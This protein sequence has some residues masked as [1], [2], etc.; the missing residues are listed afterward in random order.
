MKDNTR[1]RWERPRLGMPGTEG[2]WIFVFIDMLIFLLIFLT[3]MLERAKHPAVFLSSQIRLDE[4]FGVVNTLILLTSSLM[5][6]QAVR[7]LRAYRPKSVASYLGA[8]LLLGLAFSASKITEYTLDVRSDITPAA[9]SF[10]SYYFFITFV[11]FLHVIA[12]MVT[13]AYYRRV[14]STSKS[15]QDHITSLEN[16]GLFWHYV[17]VLWIYIF[18]LLYFVGRQ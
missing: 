6:V 3:F 9:N 12:G 10:Y 1:Q 5:V 11:H 8:S 13:I 4:T 15:P 14:I 16:V 7:A 17:D 2:I 18:P